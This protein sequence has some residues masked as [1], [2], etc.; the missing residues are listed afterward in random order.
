MKKIIISL[1][2]ILFMFLLQTSVFPHI[3]IGGVVPNCLL[4]LV[5]VYGFMRGEI[6][7]M[8]AGFF[9]GFLID[10]F[11][12]DILGYF[13]LIFVLAGYINGQFNKVYF[14]E[15]YRMPIIG[16][17]VTDLLANILNYIF[18]YLLKGK[19]EFGYYFTFV[20]LPEMFYTLLFG[21]LFLP[22]INLIE[23]KL[24]NRATLEKKEKDDVL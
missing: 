19:L 4:A 20:I 3:S 11:C 7:G 9:A 24:V 12:M 13:S 18:L 17:A 8:V 16:I 23:K 21:L 5:C 15:D 22:L 2:T 10:V 6:D 14:S 1:I